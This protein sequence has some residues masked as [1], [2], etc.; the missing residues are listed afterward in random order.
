MG[1]LFGWNQAVPEP[2]SM[3]A[4]GI[5]LVALARRRKSA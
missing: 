1:T 4:L 5:G 2:T 3:V